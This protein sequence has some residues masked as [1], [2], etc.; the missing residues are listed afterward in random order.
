MHM[1]L[2][3]FPELD[4]QIVMDALQ[5]HAYPRKALSNAL[6]RGDLIRVKKGLYI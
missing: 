6:V 5:D 1:L 2:P 3:T 4:Y